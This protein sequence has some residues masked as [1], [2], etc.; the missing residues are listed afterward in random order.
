[1]A[2]DKRVTEENKAKWGPRDSNNDGIVTAEENK[3][4][5]TTTKNAKKTMKA[6]KKALK[7]DGLATITSANTNEEI[8][9]T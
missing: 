1:M 8:K 4:Y 5:K 3:K 2:K 7:N 9:V 6:T